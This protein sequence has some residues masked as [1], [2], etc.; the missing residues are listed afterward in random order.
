MATI[1]VV[2]SDPKSRGAIQ[3]E[4]DQSVL[5]NKKIGETFDGSHLGMAGYSLEITGGSDKDGFPMRRD[6]DGAGRKRIIL[7]GPP[8][9]HPERKGQRRRKSVHGNT[10][11]D[12]IAQ[13]N[14][15]VV[16]YGTTPAN[17]IF[18]TKKAKEEKAEEKPAEKKE[19]PKT[20]GT[21][22]E[23]AAPKTEEKPKEAPKKEPKPPTEQ[24][25][26]KPAEKKD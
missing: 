13:V 3:K 5:G 1:K 2:V 10:I 21:P 17:Q 20:E 16:K 9:F 4:V 14:A 18:Q 8:G 25:K 12:T 15:K 24:Q 6:V 7:T 11:D 26:E 23:A 22:K 19:A